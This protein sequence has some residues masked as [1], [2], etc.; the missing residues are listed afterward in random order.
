MFYKSIFPAVLISSF[1]ILTSCLGG[2]KEVY[3]LDN[4][5]WNQQQKFSFQWESAKGK[6][7]KVLIRS[8]GDYNYCNL[9]LKATLKNGKGEKIQEKL[10]EIFLN[11]PKTGAPLGSGFGNTNNVSATLWK[12]LPPSSD[13]KYQLELQ[14]YM[15][16]QSLIGISSVGIETQ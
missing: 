4:D 12:E 2:Y 16:E 14:H 15:R 11:N 10:K 9:Y 7:L 8:K 3:D 1:L 13:G 6:K 5:N